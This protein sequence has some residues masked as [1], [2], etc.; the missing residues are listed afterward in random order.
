VVKFR[1]LEPASHNP[2]DVRRGLGDSMGLTSIDSRVGES[3]GPL[4]KWR[5]RTILLM[6]W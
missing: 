6:R 5:V 1:N 2:A 4:R 3:V